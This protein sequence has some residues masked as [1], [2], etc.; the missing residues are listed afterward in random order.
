MSF[1][2]VGADFNNQNKPPNSGAPSGVGVGSNA[3]AAAGAGPSNPGSS[4][5]VGQAATSPAGPPGAGA[6]TSWAQA[7]GKGLPQGPSPPQSTS[8]TKQ[9]EQL[10]SMR[11]ALFAQDGW[12]GVSGSGTHLEY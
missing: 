4:P 11:E 8:A 2:F 6:N 1:I 5:S 12:G 7:A 9:I 10:N 3:P